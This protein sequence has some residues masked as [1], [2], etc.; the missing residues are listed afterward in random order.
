[1]RNLPK[2]IDIIK[3]DTVEAEDAK[4]NLAYREDK[5]DVELINSG[6]N[7][8]FYDFLLDSA[9]LVEG[10]IAAFFSNMSMDIDKFSLALKDSIHTINFSRVQL[11]S[12][13]DEIILDNFTITPNNLIGKKGFPVVDARIPHVSLK[14]K[15][16][17]SFQ[18]T[19]NI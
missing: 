17:T 5:Q 4:F 6:V 19:G 7:L 2:T 13:R 8:S 14:T 1:E 12:E 18:S 16:L 3:V 15:S 10:D 9:K 11:D